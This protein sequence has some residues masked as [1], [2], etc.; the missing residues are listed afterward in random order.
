MIFN[1][2]LKK[3]KVCLVAEAGATHTG[4]DSA[5]NLVDIA[6]S[7]GFDAVKFQIVESAKCPHPDELF[8]G[9]KCIDIWKQRELQPAEWK[10]LKAY[11][12]SKGIYSFTTI[13]DVN[14]LD[15]F[16]SDMYKIRA[17][18]AGNKE[19]IYAV[20]QACDYLQIDIS[21]NNDSPLLPATKSRLI[22]NITPIGYP[23]LPESEKLYRITQY[24][25]HGYITG[26]SSHVSETNMDLLALA[27]GVSILEKP[28]C[29]TESKSIA[30]EAEYALNPY[31]ARCWVEEISDAEKALGYI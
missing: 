6:R 20:S 3:K 29:E 28:I 27:L 19:L 21:S 14:Q 2:I 8:N 30:P 9:Y 15:W 22:V 26:Y 4:L 17:R 5:I 11:C 16:P 7:A 31:I 13:T 10:V 1:D 25:D 24:K 18:D 23:A 12:N